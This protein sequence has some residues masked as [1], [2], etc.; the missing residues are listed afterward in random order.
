MLNC[1]LARSEPSGLHDHSKQAHLQS[2]IITA[3]EWIAEFTSS[4]LPS[5]YSNS[6]YYGLH[7]LLS[8]HS[9]SASKCLP[10]HT[11]LQLPSASHTGLIF[12]LQEN[13]ERHQVVD[14]TCICNNLLS[15]PPSASV[16]LLDYHLYAH[17]KLLSSTASSLSRYTM[18]RF[19][20]YMDTLIH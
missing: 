20:S 1:K 13:L 6:L 5:Q 17:L 9:I 7:E 16:H 2:F 12:G 10:T 11:R 15:W 4:H 19:G 8:D 3:S 18:S 14:S